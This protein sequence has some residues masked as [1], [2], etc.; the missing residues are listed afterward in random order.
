M[1]S[2]EA[3]TSGWANARTPKQQAQIVQA[4]KD[5]QLVEPCEYAGDARQIFLQVKAGRVEQEFVVLVGAHVLAIEVLV[6]LVVAQAVARPLQLLEVELVQQGP[7]RAAS[8][9]V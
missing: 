6:G 3:R 9:S 2:N 4:G 8:T 5:W 1:R 7:E